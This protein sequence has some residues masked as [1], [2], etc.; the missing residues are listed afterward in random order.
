M[1]TK[2]KE[3]GAKGEI[4]A[5]EYLKKLGYEII[6]T[7]KR[8][9]RACEIDI[10]A[11]DKNT[12]VFCEVKTRSSDFCGSGFEAIT[13]TKYEHIKT[14]LFT[15]LQEHKIYKKFRIDA[16]S[17]VLTPSVKINHLKNI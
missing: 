2:N 13:K 5:Q 17:I 4:L 7:N 1:T 8:F 15:Y 11:K 10:I 12:L 6:E 16:I 3:T 14:G 9:S